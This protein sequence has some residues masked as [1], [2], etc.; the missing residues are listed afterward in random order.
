VKWLA[1]GAAFGAIISPA[2]SGAAVTLATTAATTATTTTTTTTTASS[3][4]TSTTAPAPTTTSSASTSTTTTAPSTSTTTSPPPPTPAINLSAIRA[5]QAAVVTQAH[6]V[7]IEFAALAVNQAEN[8]VSGDQQTLAQD[9]AQ[10]AAAAATEQ[11][12]A[13]RLTVD[14]AALLQADTQDHVA[15]ALLAA[16]RARLR[17]LALGVY[18]GALT[19]PQPAAVQ[20]LTSDQ[21]AAIDG[22]E[23]NVVAQ[24]VVSNLGIDTAAAAAADG[25]YH[26]LQAT[27]STDEVQLT[28]D[29]AQA[30]SAQRLVGPALATL[31]RAQQQLTASSGTLARAQAALRAALAAVG[32]TPATATATATGTGPGDLTIMGSS[33][34]NADQMVAWFNSQGYSD[35]TPASVS[36]LANWYISEGVAL[37]VRGDVAFA[38]AVLET[39]G[40]S[41]P[42]A[43]S[44]NNYAGIGHCD[45]CATG[46]GFPSPQGGVIGHL[47]LLRIFAGGGTAPKPAPP[48]VMPNLTPANQSRQSCCPTWESLTGVWATDPLYST[49]IL[50]I[51][52]QMLA[53]AESAAT[54]SGAPPSG[55]PQSGATQSAGAGA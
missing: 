14:Q 19:G 50:L 41:S 18:T 23:V 22:G 54:Q 26:G 21:N 11:T 25:H 2:T 1:L 30:A 7:P 52:A 45:T 24:I 37:G 10:A 15:A 6:Q 47:Q 33:A 17:G 5:A 42:D 44:L 35:L 4:S 12:A 40:F 48:P 9:Q 38:Q 13:N 27:V 32:A 51:Y 34:L 53:A 46:W 29:Q 8:A 43:V 28:A 55:A 20:S 31:T 16:D 49:Q 3:A 39:G 36:Q